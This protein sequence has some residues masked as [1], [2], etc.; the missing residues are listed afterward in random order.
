MIELG[1]SQAEQ[2]E[3]SFKVDHGWKRPLP[4][5]GMLSELIV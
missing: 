5:G 1:I 4:S 3:F 2:R